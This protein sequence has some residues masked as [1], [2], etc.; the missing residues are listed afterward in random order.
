MVHIHAYVT[1]NTCQ[2]RNGIAATRTSSHDAVQR[3]LSCALAS[4][5]QRSAY[6]YI[7]VARVDITLSSFTD[8]CGTAAH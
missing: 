7:L 5:Q 6:T 3:L 4:L 8:E 1:C 2:S